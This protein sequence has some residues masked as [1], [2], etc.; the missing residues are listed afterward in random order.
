M[1]PAAQSIEPS[2][3][4]SVG[5]SG[6]VGSE[7]SLLFTR[8]S[9]RPPLKHP[10]RLASA[11]VGREATRNGGSGSVPSTTEERQKEILK[12]KR[13]FLK[14]KEVTSSF[15]A[16]SE[17]RKKVMREVRTYMYVHVRRVL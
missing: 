3:S 1:A 16:K 10:L 2:L 11:K 8:P 14:N 13:R 5:T 7:S 9:M 17:M 15:F 12:L 4:F 6:S